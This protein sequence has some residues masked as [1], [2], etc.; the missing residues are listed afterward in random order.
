MERPDHA[1]SSDSA[2]TAARVGD[3]GRLTRAEATI[4]P[5]SQPRGANSG[6]SAR[7]ANLYE[8]H[9]PLAQLVA[10]LVR[11]EEVRSSNLLGSTDPVHEPLF[12][13]A[14]AG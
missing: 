5:E 11:I 9:G 14:L 1:L 12:G 2:C 7:D 10:R 13:V 8:H 6:P 4:F 3:F